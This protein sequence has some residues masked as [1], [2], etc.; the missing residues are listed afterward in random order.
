MTKKV[1]VTGAT[2]NG[3][4]GS[5]RQQ[6]CPG[7]GLHDVTGHGGGTAQS[8]PDY[9]KK[10]PT[11]RLPSMVV[12][13]LSHVNGDMKTIAYEL[14]KRR[15]VAGDKAQEMLLKKPYISAEEAVIASAISYPLQCQLVL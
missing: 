13:L 4:S 2:G 1:L 10:L 11:R 9:A 12:R 8:F 14:D 15:Y 6:V 5:C 3:N 7:G